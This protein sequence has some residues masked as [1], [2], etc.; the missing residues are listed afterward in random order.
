MAA[1]R[2]GATA[3]M[4]GHHA[5]RLGALEPA[6]SGAKGCV[7]MRVT[8]RDEVTSRT[9]REEGTLGVNLHGCTNVGGCWAVCACP[10]P[11]LGHT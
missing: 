3:G 8:S 5:V 2:A 9:L 10:L 11:S 7:H 4:L 6:V 1:T